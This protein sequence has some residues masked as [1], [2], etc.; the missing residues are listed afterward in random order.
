MTNNLPD[1]PH[2]RT[3]L[4][5]PFSGRQHISPRDKSGRGRFVHI[6]GEDFQVSTDNLKRGLHAFSPPKRKYMERYFERGKQ[7]CIRF[8]KK[9][10]FYEAA[11]PDQDDA[12]I[13][14]D[15]PVGGSRDPRATG[16]L[17]DDAISEASFSQ[18]NTIDTEVDDIQSCSQDINRNSHGN[19]KQ[20]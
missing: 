7:D 20:T 17:V 8:L 13:S 18:A 16:R 5:S 12:S 14:G 3:I 11:V 19:G 6:Q 1:I 2:G 9:E 15:A 10:H 4:I